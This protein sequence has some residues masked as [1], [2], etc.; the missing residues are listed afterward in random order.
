MEDASVRRRGHVEGAIDF[1]V[2][3]NRCIGAVSLGFGPDRRR[4]RRKASG[5]T[6]QEVRDKL[7]S[8]HA[9]LNVGLQC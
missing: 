3:K 2:G 6:K 4:L 7:R 5:V 1:A 8:L 9:E